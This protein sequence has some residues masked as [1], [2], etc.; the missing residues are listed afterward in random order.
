[1]V[2]IYGLLTII[3][4]KHKFIPIVRQLILK[5]TKIFRLKFHVHFLTNLIS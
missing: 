3:N 5:K 1:M 4:L 2:N